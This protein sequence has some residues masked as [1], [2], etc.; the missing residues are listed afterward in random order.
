MSCAR[1]ITS[2]F[3]G[4]QVLLHRGGQLDPQT[5]DAL[6]EDVAAESERLQRMI[7]NLLILAR[8]ERGAEVVDVVP[9]PHAPHPA[10]RR[11][12][13]AGQLAVA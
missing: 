8:V 12:A 5:R 6:L 4:S 9:G 7:E 11:R 1:P 2:I 10:R 3:G 13:R